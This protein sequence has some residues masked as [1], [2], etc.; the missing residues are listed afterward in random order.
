MPTVFSNVFVF[1]GSGSGLFPGEVRVEDR[2]I[3][4]VARGAE[5]LDRAG[6]E[7]IDGHGMTLMPGL[8]EPHTHLMFTSS[9]DRIVNEWM[10]AVERHQFYTQ[11]NAKTLLDHG[12]TSAFSGGAT[13]PA[14]EVA[15]R[16]EIAGGWIPGPRLKASSFERNVSGERMAHTQD[17]EAAR[18]FAQ[19][20]IDLGVDNMKLV[21]SGRGATEPDY[22]DR[23]NYTDSELDVVARMAHE[24]GVYL[25]C[26]AYVPAAIQQALKH[27]F[28]VIFHATLADDETIDMIAAR[29]SSVFVAPCIGILDADARLRFKTREE[30]DHHGAHEAL[31]GQR[32][33][34]PELRKRGV[35]VLPGG[36]YGFPHNPHGRDARDIELFVT[37]FG[38]TPAEA[39][40]A[41]T[42]WGGELMDMGEEL[43]QIRPRYLADLLLIDGD[44][45]RD[46]RILQ[47]RQRIAAIMQ[48]GSFYKRP[49]SS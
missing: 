1:D 43:G 28:H 13:R 4:A 33:V 25:S 26:H 31:A 2:R 6:A 8:I 41:A 24:A 16:D 5:R 27:D 47:D 22:W 30:A 19:E 44:P 18:K 34:I 3:A 15:L 7:I 35:R 45:L 46:V 17:V 39:L 40:M 21:L 42:K 37:E 23:I 48:N 14:I 12:F 29:K 10:P 36:D 49:A 32:R 9:V 11:H 38:Y 20:M